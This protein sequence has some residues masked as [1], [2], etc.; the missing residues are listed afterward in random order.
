MLAVA[1]IPHWILAVPF[2]L[3]FIA[4]PFYALL[5]LV[6]AQEC[7]SYRTFLGV[8][9]LYLFSFLMIGSLF[10]GPVLWSIRMDNSGILDDVEWG[11]LLI[12]PLVV[13]GI[14]SFFLLLLGWIFLISSLHLDSKAAERCLTCQSC[15][16]FCHEH[17]CDWG[18]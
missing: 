6:Y 9:L 14:Y 16:E 13:F 17:L 8:T 11:L 12:P 10:A 1:L 15:L 18:S 4:F 3:G 2:L 7:P 5:S